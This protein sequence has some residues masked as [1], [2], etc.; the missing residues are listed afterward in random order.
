MISLASNNITND[1]LTDN[2]ITSSKLASEDKT[3]YDQAP[4]SVRMIDSATVKALLD[5]SIND[6]CDI[7][8]GERVIGAEFITQT[9]A[10]TAGIVQIGVD[11]DARSAGADGDGLLKSC[12]A[13]SAGIYLHT[14]AS[15]RGALMDFGWFEAD[16]AGK[17]T[18]TADSNLSASSWVG[19]VIIYYTPS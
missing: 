6:L 18:I 9:P 11:G 10:G 15:Y 13:N 7:A 17:L 1:K 3:T 16:G 19:A 5:G 8:N 14:N 12:D 4:V 2:E